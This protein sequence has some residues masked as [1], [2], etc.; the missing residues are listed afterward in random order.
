MKILLLFSLIVA[1]NADAITY[2]YTYRSLIHYPKRAYYYFTQL[3]IDIY[4][5]IRDTT[6]IENLIQYLNGTDFL[7]CKDNQFCYVVNNFS[8]HTIPSSST[9]MSLCHLR[10]ND[11][12]VSDEYGLKYSYANLLPYKA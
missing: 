3:N 11:T 2:R 10:Y 12:I 1:L 4:F 7:M 6:R 8:I 5:H 9:Y